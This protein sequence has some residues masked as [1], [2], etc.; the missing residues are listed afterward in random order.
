MSMRHIVIC[1][2]STHTTIFPH[3][4]MN[5]KI[6]WEKKRVIK[7]NVCFDFL[8]NFVCNISHSKNMD[9]ERYI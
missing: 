9:R 2:L 8:Y 7:Y 6:F 4:L 1:G 5:G 3:Y